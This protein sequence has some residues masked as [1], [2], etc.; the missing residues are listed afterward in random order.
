MVDISDMI[1]ASLSKIWHLVPIVITIILF[2]KFMNKKDKKRRIN[3]NEENEKKGLT[4]ELR[5]VKK[6]EELG[7]KVIYHEIED[8]KDN[9]GIDLLCYKD[10]KTLLI[11]C[12]NC[13]NPKSITDEDIKIFHNNAIKYIK[14]NDIEKNNI[15]FRY[16]IPYSDVLNKSAIKI[17][18]DNYYNCK[19]VVL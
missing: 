19:Y 4:L 17:L 2:K 1:I 14:T 12:K 6:Y 7:Y 11:Q 16:V 13:S 3:K 10:D 9:Q 5:T 15:E 8:G 18:M